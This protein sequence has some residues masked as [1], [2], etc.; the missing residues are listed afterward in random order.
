MIC[1]NTTSIRASYR[2]FPR[3]SVLG[4]ATLR[5]IQNAEEAYFPV[6]IFPY[7]KLL[8]L[9]NNQYHPSQPQGGPAILGS[10]PS[11]MKNHRKGGRE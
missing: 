2:I 11:D 8:W 7:P 5:C 3:S 9:G 1:F 10:S 6:F 4:P